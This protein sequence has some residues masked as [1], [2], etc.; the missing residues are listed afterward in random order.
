MGVKVYGADFEAK[1]L[2]SK[3]KKF[4][5]GAI[6]AGFV[7]MLTA[8]WATRLPAIDIK[9]LAPGVD[10]TSQLRIGDI[11]TLQGRFATIIDLRPD[12]EAP[13]QPSSSVVE[14]NCKD[15]GI[16]FAYVPVPHGTI[17]DKSVRALERAIQA[18]PKAILLYC[19][20]G[21]R[22]VRT[23]CLAEASRPGGAS[24]ERILAAANAA[25]HS[26]DDL[27]SELTARI[28]HRSSKPEV[29]P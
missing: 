13:D 18:N 21:K 25:G 15:F 27:S 24:L 22:A 16:K 9:P 14:G 11:R 29:A 3:S 17:P 4:F 19:H 12:G 2:S 26:A 7:V 23:F 6:V 5:L 10:V 1:A 28:A 20:S 8:I